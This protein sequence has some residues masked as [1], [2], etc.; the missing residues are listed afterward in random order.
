TVQYTPADGTATTGNNDYRATSGTMTFNPGQ[1]SKTIAVTVNGDTNVEPD[2]TFFVNLSNPTNAGLSNSQGVGTILN[3]DASLLIAD[4][5]IT[6]GDSGT[7]NANFTVTLSQSCS[8]PVTVY[9]TTS[10]GTA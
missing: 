6:E 4:V 2:E 9:Y 7:K 1:T 8:F 5:S 10:N 3:D